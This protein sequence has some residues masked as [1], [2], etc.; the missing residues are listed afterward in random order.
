[1][2]AEDDDAMDDMDLEPL[3]Q[4]RFRLDQMSQAVIELPSDST[5]QSRG[6]P[7]SRPPDPIIF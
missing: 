4:L 5:L 6:S 3:D 2:E 7:N 1:M